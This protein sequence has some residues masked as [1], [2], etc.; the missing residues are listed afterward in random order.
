MAP[1]GGPAQVNIAGTRASLSIP[2]R[3]DGKLCEGYL[4]WE[5]C[6]ASWGMEMRL[7]EIKGMETILV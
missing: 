1:R 4:L 7:A 6:L 5:S 2:G 3:R